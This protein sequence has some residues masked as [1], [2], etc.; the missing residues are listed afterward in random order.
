MIKEYYWYYI[1][2][3]DLKRALQTDFVAEP[4]PAYSKRD[5]KPWSE[6]DEKHFVSLL[7]G[8]LEKVFNFQR[9]KSEEIVRRIQMSE[10]EVN[11]VVSRLETAS[12]PRRQ[13]VRSN[14]RA[15]SDE[16]FLVLEQALSDIIADVHDLAKFTQLNYTGFQK[17]IKK[18]DVWSFSLRFTFLIPA[19][20]ASNGFILTYR[21][22]ETGWHLRPVFAARLKAKPFFKDNYDAFIVQ[23]SKLYDLVRTKGNPVKGDSAAGG[24]QQNFVRQ[25][26]KYWVHPDNITELK[27]IILKV[28]S[29]TYSLP[30]FSSLTQ[31]APPRTRL[32]R[33]EGV[34]GGGLRHL[35]HLLR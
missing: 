16:D 10:T 14:I 7:E 33:P 19:P 8:E 28:F 11:D 13:S 26:T 21:Q 34:R 29:G 12:G 2:Y 15:P 18:H 20:S 24:T 27:L 1:A 35:L 22:K 6:D 32:Q 4:V 5:R 25:T 17:I 30:G 31:E 9:M 23:L 3:D